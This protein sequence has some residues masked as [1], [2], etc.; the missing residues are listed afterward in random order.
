MKEK[1]YNGGQ[2]TKARFRSFIMSALRGASQKWGPKWECIN[3]AFVGKGTNPKTGRPCKLHRCSS[4]GGT[5][6]K[7]QM[8]ADHI[9]PVIDPATGFDSWDEVVGRMFVE[10]SG[11]QA[12]CV[13]CHKTKTGE[14]RAVRERAKRKAAGNIAVRKRAR[15]TKGL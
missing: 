6:P 1:P 13:P 10:K 2:W 7:G 14:E 8:R 5:F 15:R 4:C 12:V 11:Y 3:E 9:N